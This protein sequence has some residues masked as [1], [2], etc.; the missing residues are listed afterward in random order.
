MGTLFQDH[1]SV[2]LGAIRVQASTT[3]TRAAGERKSLEVVSTLLLL[4]D[5]TREVGGDCLDGLAV[6]RIAAKRAARGQAA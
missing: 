3:N 4:A 1:A 5:L 6:K 2:G